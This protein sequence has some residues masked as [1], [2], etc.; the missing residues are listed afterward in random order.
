M[1]KKK[2]RSRSKGKNKKFKYKKPEVAAPRAID[3]EYAHAQQAKA[4]EKERRAKEALIQKAKAVQRELE[5]AEAK[6]RKAAAEEKKAEDSK[7]E[8]AKASDSKAEKIKDE[9]PSKEAKEEQDERRAG[10][11]R[12]E[13][14]QSKDE[15]DAAPLPVPPSFWRRNDLSVLLFA[16]ALFVGGTFL[17]RHLATPKRVGFETSA[18]TLS[19]PPVGCRHSKAVARLQAW[20]EPPPVLESPNPPRWPTQKTY[21]S[22]INLR[23]TRVCASKFTSVRVPPIE[24]CEALVPSND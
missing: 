20:R 23:E 15:E 7:S 6:K 1:S 11:R 19:D 4:D 24:T 18:C 16:L 8:E 2:K 3:E 22:S 17:T 5:A 21:I 13:D 12:K 14:S 9:K 10:D